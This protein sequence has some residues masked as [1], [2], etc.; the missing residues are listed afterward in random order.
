MCGI[1]EELVSSVKRCAETG[2]RGKPERQSCVLQC[3]H[4]ERDTC[5]YVE[6]HSAVSTFK[7]QLGWCSSNQLNPQTD[8][9][10]ASFRT[11]NSIRIWEWILQKLSVFIWCSVKS[12][13]CDGDRRNRY[14]QGDLNYTTATVVHDIWCLLQTLQPATSKLWN[15]TGCFSLNGSSF[16]RAELNVLWAF[17]WI[18]PSTAFVGM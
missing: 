1:S 11:F 17:F 6:T 9:W 8:C 3:F 4:S 5:I 10:L 13:S 15:L 16:F 18:I 12:S 14:P 2:S 7:P